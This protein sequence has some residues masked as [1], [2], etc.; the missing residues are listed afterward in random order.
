MHVLEST[1]H[2][3]HEESASVFPLWTYISTEVKQKT[4]RYIFK[5]EVVS[6]IDNA[7]IRVNYLSHHSSI[8]NT[9]DMLMIQTFK[10]LLLV[11]NFF[12]C[13]VN[14]IRERWNQTML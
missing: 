10:D 12:N 1:K 11:H 13:V 2:L 14:F 7:S 6:A 5:L 8:I 3:S 9:D 4:T